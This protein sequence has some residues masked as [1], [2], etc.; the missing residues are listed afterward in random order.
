MIQRFL[1]EGLLM[2]LQ[3]ILYALQARE[4]SPED[5]QKEIQSNVMKDIKIKNHRAIRS[6][7]WH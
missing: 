3:E 7:Y 6:A 4:I 5:A 2:N 1:K